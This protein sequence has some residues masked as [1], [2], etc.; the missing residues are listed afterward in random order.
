MIAAYMRVAIVLSEMRLVR[1][2]PHTTMTSM[3]VHKGIRN[4]LILMRRVR[5]GKSSTQR[6]VEDSPSYVGDIEYRRN[7]R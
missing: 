5:G 7:L 1:V 3:T 2:W 4:K 6:V